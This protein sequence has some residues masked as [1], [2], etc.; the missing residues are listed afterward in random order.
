MDGNP[1][2]GKL[3]V[4]K[5]TRPF[6]EQFEPVSMSVLHAT[7]TPHCSHVVQHL[8]PIPLISLFFCVS[9]WPARLYLPLC[10]LPMKMEVVWPSEMLVTCHITAWC[11]NPEDSSLTFMLKCRI[12]FINTI[13]TLSSLL[14]L[15]EQ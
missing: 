6:Q 15:S 9:Y 7:C 1:S 14:G 5:G 12:V 11:H 2:Q 13:F 10:C 3:V 8:T 4:S